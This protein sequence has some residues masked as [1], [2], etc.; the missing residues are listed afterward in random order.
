MVDI[1]DYR[2]GLK[3][4]GWFM[5]KTADDYRNY[6]KIL[7]PDKQCVE[8]YDHFLL[9]IEANKNDY[10]NIHSASP[11]HTRI[12]RSETEKYRNCELLLD[13]NNG[14][15]GVSGDHLV[16]AWVR[17][18][19]PS[20]KSQK[21]DWSFIDKRV[22]SLDPGLFETFLKCIWSP[23]NFIF[24]KKGRCEPRCKNLPRC[25]QR[26]KSG[27]LNNPCVAMNSAKANNPLQDRPDYALESIR[28]WFSNL[29]LPDEKKMGVPGLNPVLS[30]KSNRLDDLFKSWPGFVSFFRLKESFVTS[31]LKVIDLSK[32][33]PPLDTE[34]N[35]QK[36]NLVT[37]CPENKFDKRRPGQPKND[38]TCD[39]LNCEYEAYIRNSICAIMNRNEALRDIL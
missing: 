23:G 17:Y 6:K 21:T 11:N 35:W 7:D 38:M 29:N 20:R 5:P 10:P 4:V 33:T 36:D 8:E 39:Q 15:I 34:K 12:T 28:R 24:W 37:L 32:T 18:L 2:V 14:T 3:E 26:G 1:K 30:R 19:N 16:H 13:T 31:D 9:L 25:E 27:R 22:S